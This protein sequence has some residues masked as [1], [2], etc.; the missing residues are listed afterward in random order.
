MGLTTWADL[1]SPDGTI[2]TAIAGLDIILPTRV[3][4]LMVSP[5]T[6]RQGQ[7]WYHQ[8][9]STEQTTVVEIMQV[10]QDEFHYRTW[11]PTVKGMHNTVRRSVEWQGPN[12]AQGSDLW[13]RGDHSDCA[14]LTHRLLMGRRHEFGQA[15]WS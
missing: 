10:E 3:D 13:H 6:L 12:P 11:T 15:R 9:E 8:G 7:F 14:R 4:P 1:L 5:P 2:A